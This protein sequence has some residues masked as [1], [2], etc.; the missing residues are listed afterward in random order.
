MNNSKT[1]TKRRK[2]LLWRLRQT[3]KFWQPIVAVAAA[4][5]SI[6]VA[7]WNL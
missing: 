5:V 3:C 2:M 1:K 6:L 7:L 4:I